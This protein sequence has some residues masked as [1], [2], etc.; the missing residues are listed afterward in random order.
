MSA[1]KP[2]RFGP[3]QPAQPTEGERN[4][5]QEFEGEIREFIRRDISQRRQRP[6]NATQDSS[7]DNVANLI[8][9]VSS[10]S[11][12]EIDRVIG[13]LEQIRD[14]LRS[15]GERVRRELTNYAG[16]S[17]STVSSMKIIADTVAQLKP[18][19]LPPRP[20]TS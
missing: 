5:S 14:T 6:A 7:V 8:E 10:V 9:R 19:V 3:E 15:E 16:L 2:E 18:T 1:L 13:E 12:N 17:Q 11:V 4:A 20:E